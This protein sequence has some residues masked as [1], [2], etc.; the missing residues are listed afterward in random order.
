[1]LTAA[2]K[3]VKTKRTLTATETQI[4]QALFDLEANA[5]P[6]FKAEL[7]SLKFV[8]ATEIDVEGGKKAIIV[9]IPLRLQKRFNKIRPK[10]TRELEKKFSGKQVVFVAKRRILPKPTKATGA[11][12]RPRCKTLTYVHEATLN[13]IVYPVDV[14]GQRVRVRTDGSRLRIVYLDPKDRQNIEPRLKTFNAAY[15]K[16]TGKKASFEFADK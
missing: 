11:F 4:A 9:V 10:L 5:T 14:V 16:L 2:S 13:D 7:K 1:M 15:F 3:I 6:E 8:R 12:F